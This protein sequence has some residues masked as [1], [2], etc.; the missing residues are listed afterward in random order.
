MTMDKANFVQ[1]ATMSELWPKIADYLP[2]ILSPQ[3]IVIGRNSAI[4]AKCLKESGCKVFNLVGGVMLALTSRKLEGKEIVLVCCLFR[5]ETNPWGHPIL[6]RSNN[7]QHPQILQG[8]SKPISI[9]L[10][11]LSTSILIR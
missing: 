6:S 7:L 4:A 9:A 11:E 2:K 10:L 3:S 5:V 1:K 8:R